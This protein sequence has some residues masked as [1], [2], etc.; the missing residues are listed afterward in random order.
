MQLGDSSHDK[1]LSFEEFIDY[2]TDHE[3]KL[4]IVF[5]SVDTDGSSKL[6]VLAK[7]TAI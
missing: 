3:R 1:Q 7:Q 2:A 5:K 4:W 6:S